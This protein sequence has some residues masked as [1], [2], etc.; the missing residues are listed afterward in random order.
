TAGRYGNLYGKAS[1][2]TRTM[3]AADE[4][5]D[6]YPGSTALYGSGSTSAWHTEDLSGGTFIAFAPG[7]V[8]RFRSVLHRPCGPLYLA[9]EHTDALTGTM[10]GAVRSGQ[11][12]AAAIASRLRA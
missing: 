5:D 10:E 11:R 1:S 6:V 8:T 12:V 4:V 2:R 7:Q 3:L 9:G